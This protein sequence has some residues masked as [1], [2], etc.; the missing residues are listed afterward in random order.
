MERFGIVNRVI[1]DADLLERSAAFAQQ[2]AQGPTRAYAAHK[3]L[4]R[5]WA[6]G[7]LSTAD[8]AMFDIAVAHSP[9]V[10]LRDRPR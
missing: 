1:A 10:V 9:P 3:V 8:N 2:V 5:A 4:L 7:G 6:V